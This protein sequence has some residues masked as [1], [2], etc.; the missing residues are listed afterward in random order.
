MGPTAAD[1]LDS[2]QPPKLGLGWD[3]AHHQIN[4]VTRCGPR[5]HDLGSSA[6]QDQPGG[7]HAAQIGFT[8]TTHP[9]PKIIGI[10][11]LSAGRSRCNDS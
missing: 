1:L 11:E 10:A 6:A 3:I 2:P 4:P 8:H 5:G 7:E 9:P